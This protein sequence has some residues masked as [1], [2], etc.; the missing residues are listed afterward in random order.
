[1]ASVVFMGDCG[2]V[3]GAGCPPTLRHGYSISHG[4]GQKR[5]SG[6]QFYTKA[7]RAMLRPSASGNAASGVAQRSAG[8]G[9]AGDGAVVDQDPFNEDIGREQ[10]LMASVEFLIAHLKDVP[11]IIVPC[12]IG[13]VDPPT[14][15]SWISSSFGS[16]YP[17]IWN[18]Q[19]AL[20]SRGLGSCITAAYLEYEHEVAELLSM[21]YETVMQV[22]ALPVAWYTGT[23]FR[24]AARRPM[25]EVVFE[26]TF[27]ATSMAATGW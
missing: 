23:S 10:R 26:D 3:T 25:S 13:R 24:P 19:L 20:Q 22:C 1:M 17:A 7:F 12:V 8:P 14:T 2:A 15:A 21:P 27:D 9:T 18:L 6:G 4:S 11:V 16:V 5:A